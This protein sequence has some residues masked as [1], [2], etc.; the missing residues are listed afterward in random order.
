MYLTVHFTE[1]CR[2]HCPLFNGQ[3]F[4]PVGQPPANVKPTSKRYIYCIP[5]IYLLPTHKRIATQNR[6]DFISLYPQNP[7]NPRECAERSI[8][9]SCVVFHLTCSWAAAFDWPAG[10]ADDPWRP[11]TERWTS[12]SAALLQEELERREHA[13]GLGAQECGPDGSISSPAA[14]QQRLRS[15]WTSSSVSTRFTHPPPCTTDHR[16][17][18]NNNNP[19]QPA[20]MFWAK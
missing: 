4:H 10:S 19:T 15:E 8:S 5:R 1:N 9:Q 6:I 13:L 12:P 3:T 11:E 18:N 16:Q 17:T 2:V 14:L 7:L 20:M